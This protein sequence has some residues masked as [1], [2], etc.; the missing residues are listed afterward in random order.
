MGLEWFLTLVKNNEKRLNN[1]ILALVNSQSLGP[2][3]D[4]TEK[5]LTAFSHNIPK[6]RPVPDGDTTDCI[7]FEWRRSAQLFI[8]GMK[9]EQ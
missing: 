7:D 9:E 4:S 2:P 6:R 1:G 5:K 8:I 3:N